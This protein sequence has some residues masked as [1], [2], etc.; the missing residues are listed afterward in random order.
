MLFALHRS[1]TI[2]VWRI[3]TLSVLAQ[4]IVSSTSILAHL[5]P[6]TVMSDL[7]Q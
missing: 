6:A 7:Q 2:L 5:K 3:N 4:I 1:M